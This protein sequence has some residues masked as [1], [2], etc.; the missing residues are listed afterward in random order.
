MLAPNLLLVNIAE[1]IADSAHSIA[2]PHSRRKNTEIYKIVQRSVRRRREV[3]DRVRAADSVLA[4]LEIL[5]LPDPPCAIDLSVVQEEV[6]VA[7][8][9]VEVTTGV[10]AD[11]EVAAS[12]H[13]E[14]A[15]CEVSLHSVLEADNFGAVGE[16]FVCEDR[17]LAM[18]TVL[19][20]Q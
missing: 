8:R 17:L 11:P 18:A 19:D 14:V 7:R 5:I 10:S 1:L 9:R 15:C 20:W 16:E 3:E 13:A 12:V 6:R 4:P 2:N